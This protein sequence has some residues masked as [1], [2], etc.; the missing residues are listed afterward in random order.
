MTDEP[1]LS[2]SAHHDHVHPE[3]GVEQVGW[4]GQTGHVYALWEDPSLTERGSFGPLY[5][6]RGESCVHP[7]EHDTP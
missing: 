6:E 2:R 3:W 5:Q 4:I 1:L 7:D